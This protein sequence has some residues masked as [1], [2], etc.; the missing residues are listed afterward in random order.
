MGFADD[1]VDFALGLAFGGA[2]VAI[3]LSFG[4]GSREAAGR[5]RKH[6]LSLLGKDSL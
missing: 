4:L 6:W 3:A 1:I 2:V 5:H